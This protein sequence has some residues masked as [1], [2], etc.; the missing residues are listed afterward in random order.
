MAA[1]CTG[2]DEAASTS[3]TDDAEDDDVAPAT[4]PSTTMPTTM[5]TT[6]P[7]GEQSQGRQKADEYGEQ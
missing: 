6:T 7:K 5:P 3:M 4:T 2:V 1:Q